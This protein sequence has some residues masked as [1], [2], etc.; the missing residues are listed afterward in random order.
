MFFR[1][2]IKSQSITDINSYNILNYFNNSLPTNVGS[3]SNV[4][5]IG[6]S[7]N[8]ELF[9]TNDVVSSAQIGNNNNTFYQSTNPSIKSEMTLKSYGNNNDIIV[10][11]NNSISNGMSIEVIG[12]NKTVFVENK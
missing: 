7:N 6:N 12:N 3:Q 4:V 2:D 10:S 11:G 8:V 5:Q 9:L 1:V